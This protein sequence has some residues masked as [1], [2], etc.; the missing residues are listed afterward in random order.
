MSW[1]SSLMFVGL[2]GNDAVSRYVDS[3]TERSEPHLE[4][5]D[6][7]ARLIHENEHG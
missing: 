4:K 1:R 6:S 2:L 3:D 5:D 7:P